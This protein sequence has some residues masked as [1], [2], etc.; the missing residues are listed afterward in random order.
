ATKEFQ[1]YTGLFGP[2]LSNTLKIVQLPDDTVPATWSTEIAAM[3]SRAMAGKINY[4]LLANTIAH[5]W[6]GS[7]VS[8]ASK[9]EW[10]LTRGRARVAEA[11]YVEDAAGRAA[12]QEVTKDMEVG[13]LAYDTVPLSGLSRL[14]TFS[15]E[16]QALATDKGA[17]IMTML[18]WVVGDAAF[19][20]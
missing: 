18:R 9:A 8:P 12:Y 4:R 17:V 20:K 19:D 15:P 5:Q 3:S 10:L 2:P 1:F 6:W 11:R 13:A 7:S 14:D 16:F